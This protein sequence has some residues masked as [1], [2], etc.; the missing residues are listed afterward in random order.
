MPDEEARQ[1]QRNINAIRRATDSGPAI[2]VD[3]KFG[4]QTFAAL[5]SLR[6]MFARA[7]D[8]TVDY[9]RRAGRPV[10]SEIL[11]N[12]SMFYNPVATDS[13]DLPVVFDLYGSSQKAA[14]RT[15]LYIEFGGY[16]IVLTPE[17]V[18]VLVAFKDS[19]FPV[20]TRDNTYFTPYA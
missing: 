5:E 10:D 16:D 7:A 20:V 12:P 8:A 18:Q 17:E 2:T 14:L 1:L 9:Y 4:P 3:G 15:S 6:P 13:A 11:S 19:G